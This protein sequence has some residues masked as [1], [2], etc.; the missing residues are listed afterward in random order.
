MAATAI[1]GSA[2]KEYDVVASYKPSEVIKPSFVKLGWKRVKIKTFKAN[3]DKVNVKTKALDLNIQSRCEEF[4][5]LEEYNSASSNFLQLKLSKKLLDWRVQK[6]RLAQPVYFQYQAPSSKKAFVVAQFN[7]STIM[8]LDQR[9][10]SEDALFE[11]LEQIV[12]WSKQ[13]KLSNIISET[14]CL[15]SQNVF[16]NFFSSASHQKAECYFKFSEQIDKEKKIILTPLAT[17]ILLR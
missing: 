4:I 7:L 16:E 2:L 5:G 9:F 11:V 10:S 15:K 12:N 1:L 3:L 14:S 6:Y 13:K 17:D 8:L